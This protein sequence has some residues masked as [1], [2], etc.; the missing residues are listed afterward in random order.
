MSGRIISHTHRGTEGSH[1]GGKF[2]GFPGADRPGFRCASLEQPGAASQHTTGAVLI[3]RQSFS[4]IRLLQPPPFLRLVAGAVVQSRLSQHRAARV[5]P[6]GSS[7]R[8][9]DSGSP[10]THRTRGTRAAPVKP[11]LDGEM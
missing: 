11:C 9:L 8:I 5:W 2:M 10:E 3:N 7:K 4:D 6:L 1:H